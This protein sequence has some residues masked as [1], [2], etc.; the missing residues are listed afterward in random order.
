M[1]SKPRAEKVNQIQTNGLLPS[2]CYR[3]EFTQV[4]AEL[5]MVFCM[6]LSFR[7][8]MVLEERLFCTEMIRCIVPEFH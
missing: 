1:V 7:I 2:V 6:R 4:S 8:R 3:H 5:K